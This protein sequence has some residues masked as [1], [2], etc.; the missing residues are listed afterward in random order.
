MS[1]TKVKKA[2]QRDGDRR[3]DRRRQGRRGVPQSAAA[4]SPFTPIAELRV[5]VQLP[6]GALVAPDGSI[7][8]LCVPRFDSPSVFGSLLD[9]GAG[10]F[11]LSPFGI[12]VPSRPRLR[13]GHQL[14]GHVVEDAD[15]LGARP[16]L[17]D[18]GPAARRGQRPRHTPA[19][20]PTRTPSTCWCARLDASRAAV[21]ID[22]VCEPAFDYGRVPA[23]WSLSDDRHRAD[24]SGAGQTLRLQT[25]MLIGIE[26]GRA[27]ARHVLKD[28]R[29]R[30]LRARLG[31]GGAR[32][33]HGRRGVRAARG[34]HP[35]LAELARAAHGSP[36]TSSAR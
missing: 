6:H 11:R 19:R 12:N 30:V 25:D 1:T 17:A 16:R 14:A 2:A 20:R 26:A 3:G 10:S 22:L 27:R 13:A 18:H 23:E 31:R 9:R 35:V 32:P 34:H 5:P 24:A 33:E 8:W 7:D 36:T 21:E 29:G 15:R 4:P 28:G